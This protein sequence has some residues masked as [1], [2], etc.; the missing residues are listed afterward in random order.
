MQYI[1]KFGY[2]LHINPNCSKD[3]LFPLKV[4]WCNL[5]VEEMTYVI[6]TV[7]FIILKLLREEVGKDEEKGSRRVWG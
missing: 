5:Q 1:L 7:Q 3:E 4:T 6:S 2:V